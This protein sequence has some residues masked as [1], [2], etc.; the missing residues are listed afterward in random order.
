MLQ[1][2]TKHW[3]S[4]MLLGGLLLLGGKSTL[5][6][7]RAYRYRVVL[8]DK[9]GT[10]YAVERPEEFL[11]P[12]ALERRQRFGL[13][14]DEKDLPLSPV[15]LKTIAS[16]GARILNY[17]KW[18]NTV[19]VEVG[20]KSDISKIEQLPFV[21]HCVLVYA[22]SER[23]LEKTSSSRV[24]LQEVFLPKQKSWYGV[25]E[26]QNEMLDVQP[27][28]ARGYCGEGMHIAV[29]DAGFL[30][31]DSLE[32]LRSIRVLDTRNFVHSQR[33]VYEGH[34]H[35][36]M[37]LSCLALH[38]PH[39]MV[40]TAPAACYYLLQ[41]EDA[42]AEYRGEEDNWCAALE[43]AD[44]VGVDLVTTSLGYV[45]YD[46]PPQRLAHEELDGRTHLISRSASL[47]A[48]RGLVLLCSAGNSGEGAW[49]KVAFPADAHDILTV[50]AVDAQRMPCR[51][52]SRGYTADGRVKPDVVAMG[53]P[54]WVM[55]PTGAFAQVEGT[56]FATPV[57]AGAVACLMQACP[58]AAP[59]LLLQAVRANASHA[60]SP[61]EAEGYGVPNLWKAY[62]SLRLH[63]AQGESEKHS[64]P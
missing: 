35:G 41:S 43:Y 19:Q 22:A 45:Q 28:H 10:P 29:I 1:V 36:T 11:S 57:L 44:S 20:R 34:A 21:Q 12:R 61:D 7:E 63:E 58:W 14:I 56:S 42:E 60:Q 3:F 27:L 48:S 23:S 8:T 26:V 64:L 15:Y 2:R 16:N 39:A 31:A 25:A 53:S 5:L 4:R 47:A 52:S 59:P 50:G 24:P 40:G 37:V 62:Q 17:S 32:A 49:R 38:A 9:C 18:N 55:E 33:S 6:A 46:S 51:F 30:N 13:K 54:V